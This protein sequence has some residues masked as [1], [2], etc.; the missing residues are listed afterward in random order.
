MWS[1]N[2]TSEKSDNSEIFAPN[3]WQVMGSTYY[4]P[5]PR[6]RLSRKQGFA[7]FVVVSAITYA[8]TYLLVRVLG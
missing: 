3:R 8:V 1:K 6:R 2:S 5:R 4:V 7:I